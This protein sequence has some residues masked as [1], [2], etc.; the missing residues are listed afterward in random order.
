[1]KRNTWLALWIVA[2]VLLGTGIANAHVPYFEHNDWSEQNPFIVQNGVEQ[3]IAVYSW[4][5]FGSWVRGTIDVDVYM[6]EIAEPTQLYIG[7]IVPAC[8]GYEEFL[9]W[10][11]IVGPGL[12]DPG[13]MV[14]FDIPEDYGAIIVENFA[15]GEERDK[16][17]EPFGGKWYYDGPVYD[18]WVDEPGVYYIYY[19]DPYG[20]GGDYSA[21]IG[22][23]EIW[24]LVEI[25]RALI[26]TPL[27]RQDQEL[28]L[29]CVLPWS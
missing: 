26:Y 15:P 28:H 5:E 14:P 1:M 29:E 20:I 10:F 18:D 16:F 11:A 24:G 7:S 17:Y 2:S 4:L 19:W 6:F 22:D 23:K 3:S 21:I 13:M 8:V 9:P 25:I 27:I 12:P